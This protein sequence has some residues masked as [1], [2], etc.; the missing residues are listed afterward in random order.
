MRARSNVP[1]KRRTKKILKSARGYQAGRGR[2]YRT[3]K[4]QH[5]RAMEHAFFGRK[6]RKRDFRALWITR[7]HAALQPHDISYSRFIYGLKRSGVALNRKAVAELAVSDPEAFR[8][9]VELAKAVAEP[10]RIA[11]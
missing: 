4:T 8:R 2:L 5:I 9:L 1:R 10:S 11:Q 3:A 7:I 6:Q